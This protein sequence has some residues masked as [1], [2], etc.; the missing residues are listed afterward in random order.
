MVSARSLRSTRWNSVLHP[1]T[2]RTFRR[3][4]HGR[5]ARRRSTHCA[6]SGA[7][8]PD[9]GREVDRLRT[10][11]ACA[12]RDPARLDALG[13]EPDRSGSRRHSRSLQY[14]ACRCSRIGI[15][16]PT[17]MQWRS[18]APAWPRACCGRS[19]SAW[20]LS[21]ARGES[22]AIDLR[23]LPMTAADRSELEQQPRP[24]RRRGEAERRRRERAL[25]NPLQRGLV[26]A[27]FRRR[28]A[29]SRPNGSR[30][31][32]CR[33]FSCR[34]TTISRPRPRACRDLAARHPD[35]EE[36]GAHV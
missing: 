22:A 36:P 33:R 14:R 34:T 32:R 25:G 13:P 7:C 12:G 4:G 18:F 19:P 29:R 20:R 9:D 35:R 23:S 11:A 1:G 15:M 24:R 6:R 2:V 28:R 17:A 10:A 16:R 21:P 8:R 27:P 26:G 3:T 5:T 30:S 31:P